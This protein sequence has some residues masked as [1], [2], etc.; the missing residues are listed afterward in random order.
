M[1]ERVCAHIRLRITFNSDLECRQL[2]YSLFITIFWIQS[3]AITDL[4]I[5]HVILSL[6]P[7]LAH[8]QCWTS[9]RIFPHT[10]SAYRGLLPR[11]SCLFASLPYGGKVVKGKRWFF[12]RT[13][14]NSFLYDVSEGQNITV[15]GARLFRPT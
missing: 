5:L 8:Y 1:A 14:M 10:S 7:E 13:L 3:Q 2:R 6:I 15:S 11:N 4:C 9:G 12:F